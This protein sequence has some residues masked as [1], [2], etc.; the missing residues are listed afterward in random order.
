MS[1]PGA[2]LYR[3]PALSVSGPGAL[4]A[5]CFRP[6]RSLYRAP[7][8][9]V[10]GSCALCVGPP[11][12][13]CFRPRCYLVRAPALSV[14]GPGPL[15]GALCAGPLCRDL[16][17]APGPGCCFLCWAGERWAMSSAGALDLCRATR[18]PSALCVGARRLDLCWVEA[19][20]PR[21]SLTP[22]HVR[23]PS[24]QIRRSACHP[25]SLR[26]PVPI[27]VPLCGPP[28][29]VRGFRPS[30]PSSDPLATQS[31]LSAPANQSA[32]HP[33]GRESTAPIR[34]PPSR[35]VVCWPPAQIRVPPIQPGAFH[36]SRREPQAFLLLSPHSQH[37]CA[38]VR[39]REFRTQLSCCFT[40]TQ[41]HLRRMSLVLSSC[42]FHLAVQAISM[43]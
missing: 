17:Q 13:L 19:L 22:I 11:G 34:V 36:F 28:Y 24:T 30:G 16:C 32:C 39:F 20:S 12:A 3:G 29:P 5:L 7:A 10:A 8:L 33:S 25:S 1:G 43:I 2:L 6:R 9:S 4:P 35:C 23:G 42:C 41:S 18:L 27:R 38:A 15:C 37:S 21:R 26:A 31:H 14:S 40:Q